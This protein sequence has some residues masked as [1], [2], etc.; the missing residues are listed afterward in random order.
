MLFVQCTFWE[1]VIATNV[2]PG[3]Y[4]LICNYSPSKHLKR[5]RIIADAE[6]TVAFEK[7]MKR[8]EISQGVTI[9]KLWGHTF[10]FPS[11]K[12]QPS[13]GLCPLKSPLS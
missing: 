8:S 13:L 10:L 9:N 11:S 2:S 1:V 5:W 6:H 4:S 12:Q 7:A 3:R